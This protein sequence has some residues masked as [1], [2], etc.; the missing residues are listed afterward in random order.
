M[1]DE[2]RDVTE[3][4]VK[5]WPGWTKI[6]I[7]TSRLYVS[8]GGTQV[9]A[10]QFMQLS[11]KYKSQGYIPESEIRP[12]NPD[13]SKTKGFVQNITSPKK[14]NDPPDDVPRQQGIGEII[15]DNESRTKPTSRRSKHP[16]PDSATLAIG[17]KK[18]ALLIT[19]GVIASMIL[20]DDRAAL[21][22]E[23]ATALGIALG[24]LIEPTELNE[25]FGWL[26]AETGDWQMVGYIAVKYFGRVNAVLKEQAAAR[27]AQRQ[28]APQ[29]QYQ[30]QQQDASSNGRTPGQT[31]VPFTNVSQGR[32]TPVGVGNQ[33]GA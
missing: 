16:R 24:N 6:Q 25:K 23:E 1:A 28:G 27:R 19:S 29:Q 3:H 4:E 7:G 30:P 2:E 18:L 10:W 33:L 13:T 20:H 14:K 8:P 5:D 15:E 17:F 9:S 31:P 32:I 21:S 11:R 26:V 12:Y 22:D